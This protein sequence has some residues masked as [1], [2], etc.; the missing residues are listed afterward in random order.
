MFT[1]K[2]KRI[3]LYVVLANLV[4]LVFWGLL[5][6]LVFNEAELVAQKNRNIARLEEER[7]TGTIL[8][9]FYNQS[10][11][12]R[13]FLAEYFYDSNSIIYLIELIEENARRAGVTLTI[14]DVEVG[15]SLKL[16]LQFQGSR[17]SALGFLDRIE[18]G[19]FV[20]K[21]DRLRW[22]KRSSFNS[23]GEDI[24]VVTVQTRIDILSFENE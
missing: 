15:D 13:A 5:F 1:K 12:E 17:E 23:E 11:E 20:V 16:S 21:F 19:R 8:S 6:Y 22:E 10:I 24:D 9:D 2:N 14:S 4:V 3:L 18:R 7:R